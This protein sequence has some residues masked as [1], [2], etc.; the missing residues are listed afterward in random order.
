MVFAR[1]Q[2]VNSV[3]SN[4]ELK[5]L[6]PNIRELDISKNLISNWTTVFLICEQLESLEWLNLRCLPIFNNLLYS[7]RNAIL[8]VRITY[9]HWM[10]VTTVFQH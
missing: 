9:S 6:C 5:E 4:T 1:L 8:T 2:N 7:T 3:G 10:I